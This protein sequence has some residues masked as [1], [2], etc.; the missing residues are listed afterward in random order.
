MRSMRRANPQPHPLGGLRRLLRTALAGA[1]RG[2][3]RLLRGAV[4]QPGH[5]ARVLARL[6]MRATVRRQDKTETRLP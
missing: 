6:R 2:M 5:L 3:R 1:R 4:R